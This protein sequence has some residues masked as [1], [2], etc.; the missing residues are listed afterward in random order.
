MTITEGSLAGGLAKY[1]A[2][3]QLSDFKIICGAHVFNVHKIILAA[4]SDYFE[5]VICGGFKESI[6]GVIELR[7][8]DHA[9]PDDTHD[10]PAMVKIL[11]DY[12]Y[13]Q[14]YEFEEPC[15]PSRKKIKLTI[16]S[17]NGHVLSKPQVKRTASDDMIGHARVFA[18]ALKYGVPALKRA[19][20]DKFQNTIKTQWSHNDFPSVIEEVYSSTPDEVRELREVVARTILKNPKS[21]QSKEVEATIRSIDGLAFDLLKLK[22]N[23]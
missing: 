7:P 13:L 23:K 3:S 15:M 10:D 20:V 22:T 12:F 8:F 21:L 14:D 11:V 9:Q 19:A 6:E 4:Q 18:I 2:S 5:A 17:G 16:N 1:L